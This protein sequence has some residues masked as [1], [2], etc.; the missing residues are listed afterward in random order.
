MFK[1]QDFKSET[2]SI[3]YVNSFTNVISIA[4]EKKVHELLTF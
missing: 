1:L 3:K 4:E 2:K